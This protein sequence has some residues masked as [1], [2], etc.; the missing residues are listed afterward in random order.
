M[1]SGIGQA[2]ARQSLAEMRWGI[3]IAVLIGGLISMMI[4]ISGTLITGEFSFLNVAQTL[5]SRLGSW[6]SALFAFGLFAAGFSSAL[7]APLAAAIT[8]QSLLGWTSWSAPY[9]ATWLGVMGVGMTFGLL[10]AKPVPVIVLAQVANGLLLPVVTLFLLVAV[11]NKTLL[12]EQYRNNIWQN[13]A[14]V[15]I[16]GVTTFLGLRN[17]WLAFQ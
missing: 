17:V 9:R 5:A 15:A 11:N 1:G 7:T 4:L 13:L 2:G 6:A 16:V 3:G 10:G 8:G 14:L 12:P